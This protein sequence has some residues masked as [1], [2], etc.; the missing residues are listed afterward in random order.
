MVRGTLPKPQKNAD[1]AFVPFVPE[2]P[3]ASSS[4]PA[5]KELPS[6]ARSES[7]NLGPK[8]SSP[9]PSQA[10]PTSS[11]GRPPPSRA[12]AE[13][14][15]SS[16]SSA[17]TVA[18]TIA[19]ASR[20]DSGPSRGRGR[21]EGSGFQPRDVAPPEPW[22]NRLAS[23]PKDDRGVSL[24]PNPAERGP[25]WFAN[26]SIPEMGTA[27]NP[28]PGTSR[29]CDPQNP[30]SPEAALDRRRSWYRRAS[31]SRAAA[32]PPPPADAGP[33]RMLSAEAKETPRAWQGVESPSAEPEV[34]TA[35]E[36]S[37]THRTVMDRSVAARCA[38]AS[39]PEPA[40][41]IRGE[42]GTD[43]DAK[44]RANAET[45]RRRDAVSFSES[46]TAGT[47][48]FSFSFFAV[49]STLP[50]PPSSAAVRQSQASPAANAAARPPAAAAR[51]SAGASPGRA[52]HRAARR[53]LADAASRA[54][55]SAQAEEDV[56]TESTANARI[57]SRGVVFADGGVSVAYPRFTFGSTTRTANEAH[58]LSAPRVAAAR[59]A[60]A[61]SP[62][63][64]VFCFRF[65]S[66]RVRFAFDSRGIV[67]AFDFGTRSR[68]V[69][70]TD[71][72]KS[73]RQDKHE[74]RLGDER[75][76]D[77]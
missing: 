34:E 16:R 35:S 76:D 21:N 9:S 59:R 65:V 69:F 54:H 42:P 49:T 22:L 26:R 40:V 47:P 15:S 27:A 51:A 77:G 33:A 11:S 38:P 29:S 61:T 68:R 55:H 1:R 60:R 45:A 71:A 72:R 23:V 62:A 7:A 50:S 74:S 36:S 13:A 67:G 8:S 32:P 43:V 30:S 12:S 44:A 56:P 41:A 66:L 18:E 46:R 25:D 4:A 24:V 37:A 52:A 57:A 63:R 10:R 58:A 64:R 31:E 73:L 70:G 20:R 53:G 17:R 39:V 6:S 2:S 48:S 28:S 5:A 14:G 3:L 75:V 19:A